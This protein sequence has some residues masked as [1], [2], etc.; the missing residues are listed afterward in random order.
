[1]NP[2]IPRPSVSYV[3]YISRANPPDYCP[4][5]GKRLA[6]ASLMKKELRESRFR[7]DLQT[8]PIFRDLVGY[9][10]EKEQN[11]QTIG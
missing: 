8:W 7:N 5:F 2:V 10:A 3:R 1:M 6:N 4:F 11:N 9:L